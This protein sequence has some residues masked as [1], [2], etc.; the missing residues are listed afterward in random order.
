[1]SHVSRDLLELRNAKLV[2]IESDSGTG[3]NRIAVFLWSFTEVAKV[4]SLEVSCLYIADDS[5]GMLDKQ[6]LY[7]RFYRNF[8][9]I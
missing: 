3:V 7:V 4:G 9:L 2:V 5:R 8:F 1:M 6:L